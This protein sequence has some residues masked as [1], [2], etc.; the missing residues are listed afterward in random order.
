MYQLGI[1]L[2]SASVKLALFQNG[3]VIQTWLC[4]HHGQ[5]AK[6]LQEGLTALN[7]PQTPI[8]VAVTGSNRSG[9][10]HLLP[11]CPQ[12]DE[13]PAITEGVRFLAPQAKS[14]I[15]IGSQAARFLT[16]LEQPVPRF[17]VN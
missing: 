13:I 14:A 17:A 1:D 3:I 9:V 8:A 11:N 15:E 16:H 12:L 2:G 4:V 6:T 10:C 5:I 7:L